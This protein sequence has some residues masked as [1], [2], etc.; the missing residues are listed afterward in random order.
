MLRPASKRPSRFKQWKP[1]K[2]PAVLKMEERGRFRGSARGRGYDTR[3]DRLSVAFRKRNPW[4]A[5]CLRRGRDTLADVTDHIIPHA[6]RPD[7]KHEWKNLAGLC[8]ACHSGWKQA[9]EQFARET[10]Q[11]ERLP[12][13][14]EDMGARP[15][16]FRPPE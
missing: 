3:W 10:G 9:M 6:E 11:V 13:W 2:S 16:R 7:L 5:E 4:C 8:N 12:L 1:P 15:K 14:C